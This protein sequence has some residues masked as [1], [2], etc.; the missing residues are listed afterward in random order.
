M[1]RRLGASMNTRVLLHIVLF[2]FTSGLPAPLLATPLTCYGTPGEAQAAA[3]EDV[4]NLTIDDVPYKHGPQQREYGT[5]VYESDQVEDCF[6]YLTPLPGDDG[7][8]LLA[9]EFLARARH[10]G[11]PLSIIHSHNNPE[12][13]GYDVSEFD[14]DWA[15]DN[16]IPVYA[17]ANGFEG[18]CLSSWNPANPGSS[19][20]ECDPWWAPEPDT[21]LLLVFG[22]LSLMLVKRVGGRVVDLKPGRPM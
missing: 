15:N 11:I 8:W 1:R 19:G 6:Q 20:T 10:E 17:A 3:T 14:I 9:D 18:S 4:R 22:L 16:H 12:V 5:A 21:L 7:E 2:L 13:N